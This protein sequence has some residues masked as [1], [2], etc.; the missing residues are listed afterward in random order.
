MSALLA[1]RGFLRGLAALPLVGGSVAL[2]GQPTAV[3]AEPS[4]KLIGAYAEWLRIEQAA[5]IQSLGLWDSCTIPVMPG[6]G[7]AQLWHRDNL[8]LGPTAAPETRAALVLAAIGL[9][10]DAARHGGPRR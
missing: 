6:A 2:V 1:R 9:D 7:A 3:A 10:P 8:R 4:P 5:L